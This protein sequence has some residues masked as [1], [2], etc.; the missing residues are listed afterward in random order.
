MSKI[1]SGFVKGKELDLFVNELN[2]VS[3]SLNSGVKF[4]QSYTWAGMSDVEPIDIL[5]VVL[6]NLELDEIVKP[7]ACDF[8]VHRRLLHHINED[9]QWVK[10]AV[11]NLSQEIQKEEIE[12]E[13]AKEED[14]EEVKAMVEDKPES[15]IPATTS[16]RTPHTPTV[17]RSVASGSYETRLGL[18]EALVSDLKDQIEIF[19]P[20][21]RV[22]SS[23][24]V[25]LGLHFFVSIELALVIAF[26]R[27]Y[28]YLYPYPPS[29]F[30]DAKGEK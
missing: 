29:L 3:F 18:L 15:S 21:L 14:T 11:A 27:F 1:A 19:G 5:R 4:F 9:D 20:V 13:E 26:C 22:G 17:G 23:G 30:D 12:D 25:A 24:S 28:P 6:D 7:F 8:D 10:K 16:P 2:A